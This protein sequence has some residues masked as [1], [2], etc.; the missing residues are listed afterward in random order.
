[1]S[2]LSFLTM[3]TFIIHQ[4]GRVTDRERQHKKTDRYMHHAIT[5]IES[6]QSSYAQN[7]ATHGRG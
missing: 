5:V 6:S 3:N 1:M 7:N 4:Y 2:V